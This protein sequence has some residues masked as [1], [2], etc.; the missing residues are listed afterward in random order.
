[1]TYHW[2]NGIGATP[3]TLSLQNTASGQTYGP[4]QAVGTGSPVQNA[5]WTVY[6]C[7]QVPAGTYRVIDSCHATWSHNLTSGQKGFTRV[8]VA[9]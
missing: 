7:T 6:P 4:W 1:M 3:G 5:D 9:D 2:N 8:I